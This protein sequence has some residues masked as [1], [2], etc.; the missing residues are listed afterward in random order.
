MPSSA[1]SA[2]AANGSAGGRRRL[3][4]PHHSVSTARPSTAPEQVAPS[5]A[6]PGTNLVGDPSFEAGHSYWS[7]YDAQGYE[8]ICSVAYCGTDPAYGPRTGSWWAWMGALYA[9]DTSQVYQEV[10]FPACGAS[11]TLTFY[12]KIYAESGAGSNETMWVFVDDTPVWG[13][14]ALQKSPYSSYALVTVN[15]SAF[16]DGAAHY[17]TFQTDI[18]GAYYVS[19][20]VDDVSLVGG[21]TPGCLVQG[22]TS[23]GG[24]TVTASGGYTTVS[25]ATTHNYTLTLP[26]GWSGTV[27]P[28]LAGYGFYPANY[29]YSNLSANQT[30]QNFTAAASDSTVHIGGVLRGEH[31]IPSGEPITPQYS[32]IM[33][34]PVQVHSK[35]GNIL[36][37]ER[38]FY[39]PYETFNEVM[40]FPNTQLTNHYWFPWYDNISM[41][42]WILV[43]NPSSTPGDIAHVT[44]KI[45]GDVVG[46]Y[47][48]GPL[49]NVTPLYDNIMDG[50]VEVI[51]DLDVF[52][53]E[54]ALY[55]S[56]TSFNETLGFPHDQLTNHYWF[57]WY[58]NKS[59]HTWILVGNP[60]SIP[61]EIAH[62][63]IKIAGA[64]V[65]TYD[66]N[67]GDRVTPMYDNVMDGPVEVTSD[68]TV[69]TS[70][71]SLYGP[72]NT[73]NE[74]MGYPDNQLT[75]HYWFPWYDSS[76]MS[77]WI[78]IGNPSSTPGDIA[79]VTVK[80]GGNVVGTYE[81]D[82]FKNVTPMFGIVPDG[83]VEIISDLN[84]FASERAL[85]GAAQS[86]NEVMAFPN[87]QLTTD[88]LFTW[89]DNVSMSTIL[90]I[91]RP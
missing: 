73:F 76:S 78:L 51:S 52:T 33:N 34:G 13:V 82:A 44:V 38:G 26:A 48:I 62:V 77:T 3:L 30:L 63:T 28:T 42:T 46:T 40:G 64:E 24:V 12:L 66:V 47:D 86:F 75:N 50:P 18:T 84:V 72:Y 4:A 89:Y 22:N 91:V 17:L 56:A 5:F 60:S 6:P 90:P 15:V 19:M 79:H 2:T 11:A 61:G 1:A 31:Y 9:P 53:S 7:D 55:G 8:V 74:T 88:Y 80:I 43:G 27:T 59:M 69:F 67:P 83:P 16:A 68:L 10:V 14:S 39:G 49:G 57:P 45:A 20:N 58:D 32:G 87:D 35:S 71:R 25:D 54:R 37:S 41:T 21:T 29:A 85:S 23:I 70:E 65:G 36:P 81:I